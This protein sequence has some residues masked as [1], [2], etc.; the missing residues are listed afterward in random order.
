MNTSNWSVL[1]WNE[2]I[3]PEMAD[4]DILIVYRDG[5]RQ[6]WKIV[7]VIGTEFVGDTRVLLVEEENDISIILQNDKGKCWEAYMVLE[8][9]E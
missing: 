3:Q 1:T 7:K 2:L 8:S 6:H 9:E 5:P 4:R